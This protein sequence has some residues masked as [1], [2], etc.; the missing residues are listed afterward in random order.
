MVLVLMETWYAVIQLEASITRISQFQTSAGLKSNINISL[1]IFF[2]CQ[3]DHYFKKKIY[4]FLH[5]KPFLS[6]KTIFYN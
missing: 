5:L 3:N 4:L 2:Y 1:K 6:I